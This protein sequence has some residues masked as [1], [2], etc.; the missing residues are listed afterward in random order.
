[1]TRRQVEAS[2]LEKP[3]VIS[4]QK[5][6]M[7]TIEHGAMLIKPIMCGICG[8]DKHGFTGEALQYAGTRR[9]IIGPYPAMMERSFEDLTQQAIV[10]GS[11][12]SVKDLDEAI[13]VYLADHNPRAKRYVWR[14]KG[15]EVLRKIGKAWKAATG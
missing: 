10:N 11:F 8:T 1:M 5:F 3:G 2:V 9:E 4:V 12:Q 15:A 13:D 6:P 7:P 14:A